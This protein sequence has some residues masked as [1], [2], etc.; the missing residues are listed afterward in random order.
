M[1]TKASR[2]IL[3]TAIISRLVLET[4]GKMARS[5]LKALPIEARVKTASQLVYRAGIFLDLW[6][7]YRG[8][9]RDDILNT[10]N[11]YPGFFLWD[12]HA[13]QVS[14]VI[15]A[16]GLFETKDNTINLGQL[17][18]E[19]RADRRISANEG[20]RIDNLFESVSKVSN[21][22]TIIRSNAFAHRSDTMT[23]NDAFEK[24]GI[25][26]DDL[27]NLMRVALQIINI[28]LA[29]CGLHAIEFYPLALEDAK[30]VLAALSP[31]CLS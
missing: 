1:I 14:F 16:G 29:A 4:G 7:F 15:H 30:R 8:P 18:K 5:R 2:S 19:L 28:C 25:S 3:I 10:M 12:E 23:L 13:H 20:L 24:A 22:V 31:N 11:I 21:G 17:V 26:L 6:D 27:R 9:T